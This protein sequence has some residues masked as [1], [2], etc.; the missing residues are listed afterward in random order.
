MK[1]IVQLFL[2]LS[3]VASC[4]TQPE[5][6]E[7]TTG[8]LTVPQLFIAL[9]GVGPT[10]QTFIQ[11]VPI[12]TAPGACRAGTCGT[13]YEFGS[14]AR[15]NV[16]SVNN[17]THYTNIAYFNGQ[18][19][20]FQD[21][22]V[23]GPTNSGYNANHIACG[24]VDFGTSFNQDTNILRNSYFQA[25]LG[26]YGAVPST[27]PNPGSS[28]VGTLGT[29]RCRDANAGGWS[30]RDVKSWVVWFNNV[31]GKGLVPDGN[32]TTAV[33]VARIDI[34]FP[35]WGVTKRYYFYAAKAP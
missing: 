32:S 33:V 30:D 6:V 31:N 3:L 15:I 14:T 26:G 4:G 28:G 11:Q 5:P 29:G 10:D 25:S 34:D 9:T 35:E 8:A 13:R 12:G 27:W 20:T 23:I 17:A 19:T 7:K 24:F 18:P 16:L 1:R 22:L 21:K 2:A